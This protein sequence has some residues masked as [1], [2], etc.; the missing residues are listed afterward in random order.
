MCVFQALRGILF[1][2]TGG[3]GAGFNS[4]WRQQALTFSNVE[5]LEYGLVQHKV[6]E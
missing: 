3:S 5:G 6:H 4:E 2:D 1:G